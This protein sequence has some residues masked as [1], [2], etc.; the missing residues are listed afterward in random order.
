MFIKFAQIAKQIH[1]ML[2][3]TPL[4]VR[5]LL[6]NIL[7]QNDKSIKFAQI[8][9]QLEPVMLKLT[10]LTIRLLHVNLLQRN[11]KFI[12][13]AQIAKLT[14]H[15]KAYTSDSKTSICQSLPTE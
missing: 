6:V 2:N 10:P 4:T 5:L 14:C 8:T 7:Q 1:V 9:K 13:F 3:L 15:V 12:K 11:D